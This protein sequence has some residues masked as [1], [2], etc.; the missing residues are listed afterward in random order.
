MSLKSDVRL[1]TAVFDQLALRE[2]KNEAEFL[3]TC[4]IELEPFVFA[5][6]NRRYGAEFQKH[7]DSCVIPTSGDRTIVLV[8]RRCHPNLQFCLQN[9]AYYARGWGITVICSDANKAYVDACLGSQVASV[10]VIPQFKGLGTAEI[11]KTEYNTLLQQSEFWSMFSETHLLMM[12]TDTYFTKPLPPSILNYD[13]VASKWPWAPNSPGGGGL[14]YR[15]SSVMKTICAQGLP[16][17]KAQDCFISDALEG[18]YL[19]PSVQDAHN[20]FGEFDFAPTMCGTHQWWTGFR[21]HSTDSIE[22]WLTC[23][24]Y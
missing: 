9:A 16:L 11:G 12:E 23:K 14:S 4:R 15:K 13:F 17:S 24:L 21:S 6:L 19:Y 8:E 3:H 2:Y 20:Y 18:K 7:W 22:A 1:L 10:R 5:S